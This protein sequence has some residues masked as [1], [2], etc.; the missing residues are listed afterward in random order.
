M[1]LVQVAGSYKNSVAASSKAAARLSDLQSRL[2]EHQLQLS[3]VQA[4]EVH[5]I[6]R[7]SFNAAL[8]LKDECASLLSSST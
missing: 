7:G 2:T 6:A 5:Y 8:S 1:R 4:V 3:Q